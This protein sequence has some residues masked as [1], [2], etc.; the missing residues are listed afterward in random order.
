[1]CSQ[2]RHGI[3]GD[4]GCRTT[5]TTSTTT[6]TTTTTTIVESGSASDD[7]CQPEIVISIG[8]SSTSG[9]TSCN[10]DT[11][12]GRIISSLFSH[13]LLLPEKS[14]K[15][16]SLESWKF[17]HPE[18]A[19]TT[20]TTAVASTAVTKPV[21]LA[22]VGI[23]FAWGDQSSRYIVQNWKSGK[24]NRFTVARDGIHNHARWHDRSRWENFHQSK[25]ITSS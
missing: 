21:R 22:P 8:T 12:N 17:Y 1:M 3:S 10:S 15:R 5:A 23:R 9:N 6:I 11:W 24:S 14:W 19:K 7:V 4:S 13:R 20:D 25:S 2:T 16:H 18:I